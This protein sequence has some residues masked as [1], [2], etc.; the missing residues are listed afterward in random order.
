MAT[1]HQS[2]E[3]NTLIHPAVLF[4]CSLFALLLLSQTLHAADEYPLREEYKDVPIISMADL[5]KR[6]KD[7]SVVDAR[8]D[9]EFNVLRIRGAINISVSGHKFTDQIREIR[10]ALGKPLVFYCNGHT[11]RKSYMA[12]R[13]AQHEGLKDSLTYDGGIHD[14]A[15]ANPALTELLGDPLTSADR[16]ISDADFRKHVISPKEFA[17][18]VGDSVVIDI[19]TPLERAGLSL[20]VGRERHV[21]LEKLKKLDR[22]I[23]KAINEGKALLAYDASGQEVRWLQYYL[24]KKGL[25]DYAFMDGGANAFFEYLKTAK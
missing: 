9:F 7:V 23:G 11:C 3:R 16:L 12:G 20:F 24:E 1:Y 4:A 18:R 15:V 8:S 21:P 2:L 10:E 19:R 5:R 13:L 6:L 14:W 22:A 17:A 25:T